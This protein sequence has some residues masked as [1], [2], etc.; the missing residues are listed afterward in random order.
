MIRP[1]GHLSPPCPP[2]PCR[3]SRFSRP[4]EMGVALAQARDGDSMGSQWGL[5]PFRIG[6]TTAEVSAIH[7]FAASRLRRRGHFATGDRLGLT[8]GDPR[9]HRRDG[10]RRDPEERP[11][12]PRTR[13][14]HGEARSEKTGGRASARTASDR[15]RSSRER[16]GRPR[17]DARGGCRSAS[18]AG[19]RGSVRGGDE[20]GEHGHELKIRRPGGLR[21]RALSRRRAPP[22]VVTAR[23]RRD[24]AGRDGAKPQV[25][26]PLR[27]R[28][29]TEGGG[30]LC[31]E[32][33]SS[34]TKRVRG[35]AR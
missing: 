14:P 9:Q 21:A 5:R 24:G 20:G 10:L 23:G 33:G 6:S 12:S 32:Y 4:G 2:P 16:R 19:G 8:S 18:S 17:R 30:G 7:W 34:R 29:P 27:R 13:A 25:T 35:L 15:D 22:A 11:E 28:P 1:W 26:G 3:D 31:P